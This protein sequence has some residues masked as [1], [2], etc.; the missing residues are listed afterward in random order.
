MQRKHHIRQINNSRNCARLKVP[1]SRIN[2]I[3]A[4]PDNVIQCIVNVITGSV[5]GFVEYPHLRVEANGPGEEISPSD[6]LGKNC[7]V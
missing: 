3:S 5:L 2:R 7:K 4:K 1:N 6:D